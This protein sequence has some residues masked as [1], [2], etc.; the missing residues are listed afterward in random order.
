[1]TRQIALELVERVAKEDSYANLL[2]PSLIK[3]ANLSA[4]DAAFLQELAFGTIRW[5]LFYNRV[6][7][8]AS[9]R[10]LADIDGMALSVLQLGCH[11][12][13]RMRVPV[14]AAINETVQLAKSELNR[15]AVGFVNAILRKVSAKTLDQWQHEIER[16]LTGF[17]ALEVRHSHPE[18]IIRSMSQALE[19]RS[20]GHTLEDSLITNNTPATVGICSLPGLSDEADLLSAGAIKARISPVGYEFKGNPASIPEVR[21]GFA[22]VQDL[23]SQL[24]ALALLEPA[25]EDDT[26]WLDMCSGPGGKAAL[27]SAVAKEK[28][29]TV[30]CNEVVPHRAKLVREAVAPTVANPL[31]LVMDGRELPGLG[32]QYSRILL[33][34]PCTG[35][36][37]LRRRPEARWRKQPSDLPELTKLQRELLS[38]A[39]EMLAPGG[40]MGYVTCSPHLNET[41]AQV[42]WFEKTYLKQVEVLNANRVLNEISP[43][44]QLDE[45]FLTAQLWPHIHGTDA[46]FI[47]LFKKKAKL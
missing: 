7:E 27:I 39:W 45:G 3:R 21:K 22:R 43:N 25:V 36:G 44:L 18:W 24:A 4:R 19:S 11:Q 32:K 15:G 47:S 40:V 12:L 14:H 10:K 41:S 17:A 2:L 23:G 42:N 29:I 28:G 8:A 31:I 46:M 38:A 20:L 26:A 33:D 1:L 37:A 13:L 34:A 9:G 5:Q 35:L 6:I 16:N 30:S